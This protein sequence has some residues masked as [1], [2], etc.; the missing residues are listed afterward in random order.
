[1]FDDTHTLCTYL[2]SVGIP[3]AHLCCRIDIVLLWSEDPYEEQV[4]PPG[5]GRKKVR[6]VYDPDSEDTTL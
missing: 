4:L 6:D 3:D 5:H 2:L 1:M